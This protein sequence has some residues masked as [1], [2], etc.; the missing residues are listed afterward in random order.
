MAMRRLNQTFT[1][2]LLLMSVAA[3]LCLSL[4]TEKVNAAG[5]NWLE[6]WSYRK[7]HQIVGSTAGAQTDY[8]SA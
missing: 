1:I 4:N 6:G 2:L 3:L 7:S 5:E 8:Q